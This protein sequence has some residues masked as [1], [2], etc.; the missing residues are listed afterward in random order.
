MSQFYVGMDLHTSNLGYIRVSQRG[1]VLQSRV[2]SGFSVSF[3][4]YGTW[5]GSA[6]GYRRLRLSERSGL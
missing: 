2:V 4:V 3:T 6:Q 5:L 1:E